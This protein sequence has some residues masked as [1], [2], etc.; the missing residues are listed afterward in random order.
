MSGSQG[1]AHGLA[2]EEAI[3]ILLELLEG[4]G[5]IPRLAK[6][7]RRG[8]AEAAGAEFKHLL[9]LTGPRHLLAPW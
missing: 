8:K 2:L 9:A 1:H 3:D 4:G 6:K 5:P 7:A